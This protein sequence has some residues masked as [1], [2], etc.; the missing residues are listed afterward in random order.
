MDA[1][2]NLARWLTKDAEDARDVVQ[3][4]YLRAYKFFDS[5]HGD[6]GRAWLLAIVRNTCFTLHRKNNV[7]HEVEEFDEEIHVPGAVA[8][9]PGGSMVV[10]PETALIESANRELVNRAIEALPRD[11]REVIVLRELEGLSYKEIAAI[12]DIPIG[13]VMSRLARGR[14][15]IQRSLLAR[16]RK[17]G[18][19]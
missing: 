4:S 18:T 12:A 17:G 11:F 6:D 8:P 9:E 1:A 19:E 15:L 7:P 5:F 3:E 10:N 16:T 2:F 14:C 13:T